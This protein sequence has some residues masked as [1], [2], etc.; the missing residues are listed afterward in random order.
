MRNR[1]Q[2]Q[3]MRYDK[4]GPVVVKALERRHF[5]ASYVKTKEEA[6]E[7]ALA[8]IPQDHTVSWGGTMTM[9]EIGLLDA[10]KMGG[11][12]TID[13]DKARNVKER[14]DLMR[15]GLL[16]DT[17][18]AS[19]NAISEDGQLVNLDGNG[20]RVAAMIYG[21]KQVIIVAGMNKVVKD[22]DSAIHRVRKF[23][24]PMRSQSFPTNKSPCMTTGTCSDCLSLDSICAYLSVIRLSRP[25]EKIKVILV[26]EDLGF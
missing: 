3:D 19:A 24:A 26:G 18:L 13:R 21:P 14:E 22:L 5:W 20:N 25:A 11:Y 15:Q 10:I 8:L 4:L 1:Y 7:K 16:A 17:F 23:V 6:C 9:Q 12:K 2:E